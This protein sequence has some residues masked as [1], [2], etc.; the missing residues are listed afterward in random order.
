[1]ASGSDSSYDMKKAVLK[2][3]RAV[4]ETSTNV[5]SA[6]SSANSTALLLTIIQQSA[7][8]QFG[9]FCDSLYLT[10]SEVFES[11]GKVQYQLAH[12]RTLT[13]FQ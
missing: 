13:T 2:D 9:R 11:V 4:L 5:P 6:E 1:M 12:E 10:L 8:Q 7:T 3:F